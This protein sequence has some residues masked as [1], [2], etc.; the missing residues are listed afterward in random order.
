LVEKAR[1]KGI[2]ITPM[3]IRQQSKDAMETPGAE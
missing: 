1:K 2:K 3:Y